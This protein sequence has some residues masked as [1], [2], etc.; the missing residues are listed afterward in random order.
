MSQD[1]KTKQRDAILAAIERLGRPL[2]AQEILDE[3]SGELPGLGLATVYRN[4]RRL[5]ESGW[6][7]EVEVMGEGKRYERAGK[8]HHHHFHCQDCDRLFE[9]EDCP[10]VDFASLLPEGFRLAAHELVLT[11][12]CASCERQSLPGQS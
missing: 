12:S 6:L 10:D 3:A 7:A 11:G 1:R 9:L 2:K 4:I 8:H 5:V